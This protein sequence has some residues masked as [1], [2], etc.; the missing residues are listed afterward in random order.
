MWIRYVIA[1]VLLLS[2]ILGGIL[3]WQASAFDRQFDDVLRLVRDKAALQ[4]VSPDRSLSDDRAV[5][6]FAKM[7]SQ[8]VPRLIACLRDQRN[9][10]RWIAVRALGR[11]QD[12]RAVGPLVVVLKS[13]TD[14]VVR[15]AAARSLGEL[16]DSLAVES[17]TSALHDHVL[18]ANAA[19]HALSLL[20]VQTG[21]A[22]S[23]QSSPTT[24]S[25]M[26]VSVAQ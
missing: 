17:L 19:R 18:V 7:G 12:R 9:D 15:S 3:W 11:L 25:T 2:V 22:P 13:D 16:K 21:T 23:P 14:P 6:E 1:G 26:P 8:A 20:G 4:S 10:I 24:F 5:E